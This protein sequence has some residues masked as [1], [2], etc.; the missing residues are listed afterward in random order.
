MKY[1]VPEQ[2]L[3]WRLKELIKEEKLESRGELKTVKDF[4]VK[5]PGQA[6]GSAAPEAATEGQ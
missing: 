6:E 1:P 2:F 4:E 5:Q 3:G